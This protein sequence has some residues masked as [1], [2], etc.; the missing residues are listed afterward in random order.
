MF[1]SL[2]INTA[3]GPTVD[4]STADPRTVER[5]RV[6]VDALRRFGVEPVLKH[7]PFLP[8]YANLHRD[9]PDTKTPVPEMKR[10]TSIFRRMLGESDLVMT[11]HTFDSLVDAEAVATLSPVWNRIIRRGI[12]FSGLLM[13]DDLLMLQNYADRRALGNE[14]TGGTAAKWAERAILSGHDF[15][16]LAGSASTTYSVFD[17]LLRAASADTAS[18]RALHRR[19]EEAHARISRFKES[20]RQSLTR[21]FD[22]SSDE[23][24]AVVEA[25]PRDPVAGDFRI[26]PD[27]LARLEDA[28]K[29]ASAGASVSERFGTVIRRFFMRMLGG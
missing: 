2:G 22:A 23:I 7:F 6:V 3:L 20:H 29:R 19:I 13:S 14:E 24:R 27:I 26:D 17:G 9:S 11:T 4:D 8:A 16:I 5:A 28:F 12:G 15:I 10:R 25:I 21:S 18:G 1:A